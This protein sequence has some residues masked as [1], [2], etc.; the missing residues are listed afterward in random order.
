VQDLAHPR[1]RLGDQPLRR[2]SLDREKPDQVLRRRQRDDVVDALVVG[3]RGFVGRRFVHGCL[4]Q[5]KT[6]RLWGW[7]FSGFSG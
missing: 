5:K 3:K 6:A 4:R 1:A 2:A 7:R